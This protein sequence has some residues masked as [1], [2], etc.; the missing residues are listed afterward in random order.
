MALKQCAIQIV[1]A[2]FRRRGVH[3]DPRSITGDSLD[4]RITG[5]R[6]DRRCRL[7]ERVTADSEQARLSDGQEF[8]L[9]AGK[10]RIV[11]GG[12]HFV[13]AFVAWCGAFSVVG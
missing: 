4:T 7:A 3:K 6:D 10:I 1:N 11:D 2:Y 9:C 13:G 5:Q 8:A 12:D